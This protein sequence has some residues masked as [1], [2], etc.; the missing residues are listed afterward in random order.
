MIGNFQREICD[1]RLEALAKG[2]SWPPTEQF[3]RS[4]DEWLS[5]FGI[6]DG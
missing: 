3:F 6:V 2:N 5:P 1:G 4:G